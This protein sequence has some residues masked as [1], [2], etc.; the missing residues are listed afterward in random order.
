MTREEWEQRDV[1]QGHYTCGSCRYWSDD[2]PDEKRRRWPSEGWCS[3]PARAHY[4]PHLGNW[5]G[6]CFMYETAEKYTG[7]TRMEL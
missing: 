2:L 6:H 5:N 4:G 3:I 1:N 7:Q